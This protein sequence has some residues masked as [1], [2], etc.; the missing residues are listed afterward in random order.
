M[1][2]FVSSSHLIHAVPCFYLVIKLSTV[3]PLGRCVNRIEVTAALGPAFSITEGI[4][5]AGSGRHV[6]A[7]VI[8]DK[9]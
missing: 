8:A 5:A 2:V 9:R 6:T 3:K 1:S 4:T 7:L